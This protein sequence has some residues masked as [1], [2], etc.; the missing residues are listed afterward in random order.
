M[1]TGMDIRA[2]TSTA[3]GP[4]IALAVVL[5]LAALLLAGLAL[6]LLGRSRRASA[7]PVDDP[8]DDLPGFLE[9]PPGTP[10]AGPVAAG[11][12]VAL[13]APPATPPPAPEPSRRPYAVI[14]AG[15]AVLVAAAAVLVVVWAPSSGER[16]H[17]AHRHPA[18]EA[19][20][21]RAV[22]A[23]MTF[24]GVVLE[25]RAVGVTVTYPEVHLTD[26]SAEFTLPTWNCLTADAPEDPVDAGC[27]RGRT[28]YAELSAPD[29]EMS[30][31][32]GTLRVSGDFPTS[33]RPAGSAPE[34]TGRVY[35]ISVEI[36]PEHAPRQ[37]RWTHATGVLD[38]AD[39][40]AESID[41]EMRGHG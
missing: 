29:L 20:P 39:R 23:R 37:G 18:S 5:G 38:L 19:R 8:Q 36:T 13:A 9:A 2:A 17:R 24:N 12:F 28:E 31:R 6:A 30:R 10:A 34:P 33:T 41:G 7:G 3:A 27:V 14:A 21:M 22:E 11:G 32:D 26:A 35:A 25:E 4:W 15:A 16:P 40:Q 1:L